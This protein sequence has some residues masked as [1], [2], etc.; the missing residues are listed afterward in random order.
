MS[1]LAFKL[2]FTAKLVSSIKPVYSSLALSLLLTAVSTSTMAHQ[3]VSMFEN[4][5]LKVL[6]AATYRNN[7]IVENDAVWQ[8]DGFLVGGEALP[9]EKGVSLDDVQLQGYLN[10]DNDYYVA[11]KLSSHSHGGENNLELENLWMGTEFTLF[12][13]M[14]L[15][16]GGKMATAVTDTLNYHASMDIFDQAPLSADVFFGRHFNDIGIRLALVE[17]ANTTPQKTQQMPVDQIDTSYKVGLEIFNGDNF[18]ASAGEGSVSAFSHFDLSYQAFHTSAKLWVMY[19]K[20]EQRADDRYSDSHNHGIT[21]DDIVESYFTGD[22]ITTGLYLDASWHTENW[23]LKGEFEWMQTQIDGQ[24]FSSTQSAFM[25]ATDNAYR[26]ATS[27]KRKQHSLHVQYEIL[28]A[29]NKFSQTTQTFIDQV[30]LNNDGF[31]PSRLSVAWLYAFHDNFVLRTQWMK[32]ESNEQSQINDVLSV[33][34][35]W[36]YDIL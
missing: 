11:A 23:L 25:D 36:Q 17:G 27:L 30:G 22:T 21:V 10:I 18:P 20:A 6:A 29:E 9:A 7:S 2:S 31:E 1:T 24:V 28:S 15:L 13:Q 14:F 5:S 26:L 16:E 35:Q 8:P 19:S 4:N 3:K 33:G 34:V 32:D 12:N